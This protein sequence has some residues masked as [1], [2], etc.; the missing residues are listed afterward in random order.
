MS[1]NYDTWKMRFGRKRP[2]QKSRLAF[3]K[4]IVTQRP[5]L[6]TLL[7]T[8]WINTHARDEQVPYY[9]SNSW[10]TFACIAGR[11]YGKSRVANEWIRYLVFN[12]HKGQP[13]EIGVVVPTAGDVSK[14]MVNGPSGIMKIMSEEELAT[15]TFFVN[16]SVVK[17]SNGSI[18][19]YFSAEN[20]ARLR[21]PQFHYMVLDELAAY[22]PGKIN[23]LFVQIAMCLRSNPPGVNPETGKRWNCQKMITTTPKP[24]AWLRRLFREAIHSDDI[25][26]AQGTT[27]D[28]QANLNETMFKELTRF[29][30]TKIGDQEVMGKLLLENDAGIVKREDIMLWNAD[31]PL[32]KFHL[33]FGS[34]D[35]AATESLQS[36]ETACVIFGIFTNPNNLKKQLMILDTWAAKL[37]YPEQRKQMLTDWARRYGDPENPLNTKKASLFIVENK[38]NGIAIL[39]DISRLGVC[40]IKYTPGRGDDKIS[41]LNSVAPLIQ[42]GTLWML[43][44][45]KNRGTVHAYFLKLFNQLCDFPLVD[46]ED[47]ATGDDLVDCVSQAMIVFRGRGLLTAEFADRDWEDV[48][49]GL[50]NVDYVGERTRNPYII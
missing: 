34:Y 14:V 18:I 2:S 11:G 39:T 15:A 29:V 5:E 21:G 38:S 20:D 1:I 44:S 16:S 10:I 46:G 12:K 23:G 27:Y 25:V 40:M 36:D 45:K 19:Y 9:Y 42:E 6:S 47:G 37:E 35:L 7:K 49:F 24:Q 33:I 32:P 8:D 26:I 43:E 30:G 22:V 28:N 31:E 3:I 17:F 41:K 13:I 50:E 48:T 4:E